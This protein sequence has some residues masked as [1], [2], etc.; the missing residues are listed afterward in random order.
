MKFT[1]RNVQISDGAKIGS[2]VRIGDNTVIYNNVEIGDNT[3]IANDCIL[4]EP[5]AEYYSNPEFKNA[6]TIIGNGSLIRSHAII[7]SGVKIGSHLETG[8]RITIRENTI[9][10]NHCRIGTQC[11]LQGYLEL[12]NY[13]RLHSSVHLCQHCK[14]GDFVF[15]YPFAVLTND[16]YPP[17]KKVLGPTVGDYTQIGVH[18]ILSGDVAVGSN[19]LI[20]A[21]TVV[22]KSFDDY[23]FV[24]GSPG[25]L[26]SDVRELKTDA[27]QNLYPWKE[28]FS[29]DLPWD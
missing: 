3:V 12:G 26:K 22:A 7:Y 6:Q 9:I 1:N 2:N 21:N 18:S 11:D 16:K 4:G 14:L 5:S 13:C 20:G 28:R 15:I 10:G 27:G 19:C 23:S 17:S 29:R 8:H 25:K 24:L